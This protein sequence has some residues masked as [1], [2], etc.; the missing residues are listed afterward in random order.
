ML[1][2]FINQVEIITSM[3]FKEL[4]YHKLVH[5]HNHKNI[6][7]CQKVSNAEVSND[8]AIASGITFFDVL[9]VLGGICQEFSCTY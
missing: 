9:G 8:I 2:A 3:A 1:R 5:K 6:M 7:V 4:L